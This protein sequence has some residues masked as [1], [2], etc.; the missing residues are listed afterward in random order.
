MI[1]PLLLL[2]L[3]GCGGN[4]ET[5][6]AEKEFKACVARELTHLADYE[7]DAYKSCANKTGYNWDLL[8]LITGKYLPKNSTEKDV[9]VKK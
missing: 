1:S 7:A 3:F 5:A 9:I 8:D 4:L 2:S 6:E